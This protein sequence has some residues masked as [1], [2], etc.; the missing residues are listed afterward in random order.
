MTVQSEPHVP[1]R[2]AVSPAGER[3]SFFGLLDAYPNLV[4]SLSLLVFLCI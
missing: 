2:Q 4:R 3:M 1:G